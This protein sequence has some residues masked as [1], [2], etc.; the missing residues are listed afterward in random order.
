M[1]AEDFNP[2]FSFDAGDFEAPAQAPWEFGGACKLGMPHSTPNTQPSPAQQQQQQRRTVGT[3][4][5]Y[6]CNTIANKLSTF[7]RTQPVQNSCVKG[8]LLTCPAGGL[9][10]DRSNIPLQAAGYLVEVYILVCSG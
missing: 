5:P 4:Q 6:S 1:A 2:G 7:P 8:C 9:N 10:M 3:A